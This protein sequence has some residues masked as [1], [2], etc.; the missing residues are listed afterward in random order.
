MK[1]AQLLRGRHRRRECL[2]RG[3]PNTTYMKSHHRHRSTAPN[4]RSER[5]PARAIKADWS[6]RSCR[7]EGWV[8]RGSPEDKL[9]LDTQ[10]VGTFPEHVSEGI[11]ILSTRR[12]STVAQI[13]PWM[14]P[15]MAAVW[16]LECL[17]SRGVSAV[18]VACAWMAMWPCCGDAASDRDPLLHASRCDMAR[19]GRGRD[20]RECHHTSGQGVYDSSARHP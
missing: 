15:N 17:R 16:R 2:E 18:S 14:A 13:A 11:Q 10:G 1:A 20:D 12:P 19:E 9:L 6:R 7:L 8:G 3:F 5:P 4:R